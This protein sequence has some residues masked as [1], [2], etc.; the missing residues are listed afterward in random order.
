M[1]KRYVQMMMALATAVAMSVPASALEMS[2]D[3]PGDPEYGKPTS[4]EVV[5]TPDGGARRNEDISKNAA[6]IPPGFGTP[7]ADTKYTGT[8]LTPNLAPGGMVT[9][10][11]VIHG[12]HSGVV[13]PGSPVPVSPGKPQQD[14]HSTGCTQVTNDLYYKGGYLAELK[15]PAVDLTVKV[16]EGTDSSTL[17][18]GAGHF[19]DTS[20]WDG[21][22]CIA[23]HNRG[24]NHHFGRLHELEMGNKITLTTKLGTR[25]YEVVSVEKVNELDDSGLAP[26][27]E[28]QLTLYTCVRNQREARWKVVAVAV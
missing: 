4:I 26:T 7:S 19:V 24:V 3:A 20:I 12:S 22:V 15:I 25:T 16:Y 11:A 8:Y 27:A 18:K 17:R 2:V 1:N 28:N 5:H 13:T 6:L 23:A 14:V 9:G 10:G 21:N